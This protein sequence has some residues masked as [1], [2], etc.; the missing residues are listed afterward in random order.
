MYFTLF[1]LSCTFDLS[2]QGNVKAKKTS[3]AISY[4]KCLV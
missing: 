3:A 4:F 1:T 2:A